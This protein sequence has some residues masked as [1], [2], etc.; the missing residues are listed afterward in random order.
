VTAHARPQVRASPGS[1]PGQ[2]FATAV[3]ASAAM[4]DAGMSAF[5][6]TVLAAW[7]SLPAGDRAAIVI[8]VVVVAVVV[9][10]TGLMLAQGD[11]LKRQLRIMQRQ[12]EIWERHLAQRPG[13]EMTYA[14]QP[15]DDDM[16]LIEFRARNTGTRTASGFYWLL[17]TPV[18]EFHELLRPDV[19]SNVLP[20]ETH[21]EIEAAKYR[22]TT[23]YHPEP[24]YPG[25]EATLA[26]SYLLKDKA[27]APFAVWWQITS[28]GGISPEHG[29]LGRMTIAV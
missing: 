27:R 16:F 19:H 18:N 13:F 29:E 9:Y 24:L 17:L 10:Q 1:P 4:I 7:A 28:E 23:L 25:R 22:Q 20:V 21:V 26:V 6:D 14:L 8:A 3:P 15:S 11:L 12:Q 5:L 2:D